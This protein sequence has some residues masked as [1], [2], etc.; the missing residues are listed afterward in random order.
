MKNLL[1]GSAALLAAVLTACTGAGLEPGSSSI[2]PPQVPAQQG[3]ARVPCAEAATRLGGPFLRIANGFGAKVED[4]AVGTVSETEATVTLK[5]GA[6]VGT[7]VRAWAFTFDRNSC[8]F[9]SG[10][11]LPGSSLI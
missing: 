2:D 11:A 5:Y 10:Y 1:R 7:A 6:R 9:D 4:V 3:A 8:I